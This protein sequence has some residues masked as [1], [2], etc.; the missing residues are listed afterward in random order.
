MLDCNRTNQCIS[1][2]V[3][4]V[5]AKIFLISKFSYLLFSKTTNQVFFFFVP[6]FCD[7]AEVGFHP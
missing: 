5:T 7:V 2:S 3:Q 1:S 4:Y 6:Q